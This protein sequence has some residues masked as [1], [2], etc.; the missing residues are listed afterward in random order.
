ML[1]FTYNNLDYTYLYYNIYTPCIYRHIVY[2][3][4]IWNQ[5]KLKNGL[6]HRNYIV[7][8]F[9]MRCVLFVPN[10]LKETFLHMNH[11]LPSAG[12][13]GWRKTLERLKNNGY[14]IGMAKDVQQYCRP[15]S[16]C[17]E[18]KQ[19]KPAKVPLV[20]S[21]IGNPWKRIAVD[22]LEVPMN[23]EGNRYILVIQEYFTK[24]AR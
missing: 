13:F 20:S 19:Y 1:H 24:C 5:L 6:L 17:M 15:C 14:W 23:S 16:R 10:Q 21:P 18:S 2:I 8:G 9:D 11:D 3:C 22:V 7:N 4:Q 12:H